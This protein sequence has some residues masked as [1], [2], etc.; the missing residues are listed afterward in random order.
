MT[1]LLIACHRQASAPLPDTDQPLALLARPTLAGPP[2][3]PATVSGKVV[4]INVWSP[5]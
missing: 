4:A 5:S 1:L 3:D 2:F